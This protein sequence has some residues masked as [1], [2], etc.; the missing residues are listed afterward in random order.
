MPTETPVAKSTFRLIPTVIFVG[1][2]LLAGVVVGLITNA[3]F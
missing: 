3:L 1:S 2:A